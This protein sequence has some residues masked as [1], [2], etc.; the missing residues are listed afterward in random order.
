MIYALQLLLKVPEIHKY[1]LF[2][3]AH[4]RAYIHA[5]KDRVLGFKTWLQM[6]PLS[7]FYDQRILHSLPF[8]LFNMNNFL[9]IHQ[10]V[11]LSKNTNNLKTVHPD[12]QENVNHYMRLG[13]F[14]NL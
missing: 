10:A 13:T 11:V 2:T 12:S 5:H 14:T 7:F 4:M 8:Q 6:M 1:T 9:S 3:Q